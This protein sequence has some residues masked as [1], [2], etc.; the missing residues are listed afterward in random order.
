MSRTHNLL[1]ALFL[2]LADLAPSCASAQATGSRPDSDVRSVVD[3]ISATNAGP[4][5]LASRQTGR[6]EGSRVHLAG[7]SVLLDTDAGV[8]T[9]AAANVDSVW[10]RR[11]TAAMTVGMIAAVPCALYAG[12]VGAVIAGDPDSN[13]GPSHVPHGAL[14]GA[15]IGGV[16]CG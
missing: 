13:G 6:L 3:V 16:V 2:I 12:L 8:R 14:V 5:R 7:D 4:V 15:V 9:I 1:A 11:G 10:V